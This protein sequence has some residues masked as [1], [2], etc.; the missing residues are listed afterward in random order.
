MP[1]A[2]NGSN[3][4]YD[5][6]SYI[7]NTTNL[8]D[9]TSNLVTSSINIDAKNYVVKHWDEIQ[10]QVEAN[11]EKEEEEK[12][13]NKVIVNKYYRSLVKHVHWSGNTCI[14]YWND[15]TMTKA[16][17]NVWEDFDPEKAMLVCM[18]RK[19]YNNS[20]LYNEVLEK[21][22][23]DGWDHFDRELTRSKLLL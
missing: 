17:W 4:G 11:K 21:Y 7:K 8:F 14:M 22:E 1:L 6:S 16:R 9:V 20:G 18:A 5:S 23:D 19:L 10:E 3:F 13:K 12:I 15:G 2:V